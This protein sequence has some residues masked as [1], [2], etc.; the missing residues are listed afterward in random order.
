MKFTIEGERHVAE[1]LRH[2]PRVV[3]EVVCP[4]R[5]VRQLQVL[6]GRSVAV[7]GQADSKVQA[8][9]RLTPLHESELLTF[10]AADKLGNMLVALDHVVDPRN[11]GAVARS[12]AFFGVRGLIVARRRQVGLTSA[13]VNVARGGFAL[14]DLFLVTNLARTL[15][16]LKKRGFWVVGADMVGEPLRDCGFDKRVLLFGAEGKGISSAVRA[17]CDCL[18]RIDGGGA[19]ASHEASA[20]GEVSKK[21]QA[22]AH[23]VQGQTLRSLNVSAAVAIFLQQHSRAVS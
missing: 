20:G 3:E 23:E 4:P 17:Q 5:L 1:Y 2:R 12:A 18:L 11:L 14:L 15:V 21:P 9:V 8:V 10:V 7:R 6:G 16:N 13:A 22:S 19:R